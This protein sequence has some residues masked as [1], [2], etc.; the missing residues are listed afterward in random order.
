MRERAFPMCS[1]SLRFGRQFLIAEQC[2]PNESPQNPRA[3]L[4][5]TQRESHN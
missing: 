2:D 4:N 1:V 3:R 5:V